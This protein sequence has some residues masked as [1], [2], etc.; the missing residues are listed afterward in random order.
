[1][2]R[3]FI[4]LNIFFGD[5][6]NFLD[7]LEQKLG[8]LKKYKYKYVI[9]IIFK[10]HSIILTA[11]TLAIGYILSSSHP[12]KVQVIYKYSDMSEQLKTI[13]DSDL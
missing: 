7:L 5:V 10:G 3:Y 9:T 13:E 11:S 12:K 2:E 6:F 1:M 4:L 8:L